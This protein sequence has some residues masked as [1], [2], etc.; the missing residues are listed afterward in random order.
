MER[1]SNETPLSHKGATSKDAIKDD[2]DDTVIYDEIL[3][4]NRA[5]ATTPATKDIQMLPNSAYQMGMKL[6]S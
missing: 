1:F 6:A 3:L 4:H 2:Y 5:E